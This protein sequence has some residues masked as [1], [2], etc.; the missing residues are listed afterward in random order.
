M[1]CFV[2]PDQ[3]GRVILGALFAILTLYPNVSSQDARYPALDRIHPG[4]LIEVD[5]LGGF[6]FDWRGRLNPE[7]FLDG[8]SKVADPIFARCKAPAE[9]AETIETAYS[10]TL[11]A[12][13]VR[14]RILD[15]SQRPVAFMEGAVKQPMRLQIRRPVSLGELV[16]VAGGFTD[17]A[18]GEV[19][20][21]RPPDQSCEGEPSDETRII[22]VTIADI[23]AGNPTANLKIFSG[24]NV[25]IEEVQ[26]VYVIGGVG[27]PGKQHWRE[28]ATVSRVVAA[29]GGASDR[30]VAGNAT[31]YRRESGTSRVIEADLDAISAGRSP[32]ILINAY[33]IIEVPLKG[34]ARRAQPPVVEDRAQRPPRG[35]LP[36]R[37]I[38]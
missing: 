37:V 29:A 5:E 7:G 35:S 24:D 18:S 28:G 3:I 2:C 9:L 10:R 1:T 31:I 32:D 25:L 17:R 22:K 14:V 16:V 20:I 34:G 36:L 33:D 26:P 8:F 23:L 11:R 19:T 6:D 27:R 38:D 21:L 15:R 30:G 12:P 4:D 13:Q